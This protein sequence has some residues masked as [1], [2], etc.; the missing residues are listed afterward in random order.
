MDKLQATFD[1]V[2]FILFFVHSN[3]TLHFGGVGKNDLRLPPPQIYSILESKTLLK[4][5]VNS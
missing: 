2:Y 3:L 1:N 5:P 4:T